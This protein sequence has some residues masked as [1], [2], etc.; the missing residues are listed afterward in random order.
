MNIG[1]WLGMVAYTCN[2]GTWEVE[3]LFVELL[4]YEFIIPFKA[5]A[6]MAIVIAS[7]CRGLRELNQALW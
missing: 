6:P 1:K 3:A 4:F 5:A 7:I 2:P